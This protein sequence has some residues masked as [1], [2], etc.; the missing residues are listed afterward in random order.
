MQPL[1]K[2]IQDAPESIPIP[3]EY[4]HHAIELIIWPLDEPVLA[5][6]EAEEPQFLVADVDEIILP[7]REER[8]ERH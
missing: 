1:R 6:D 2:L 5:A 4:H 7:T 8:N 3:S